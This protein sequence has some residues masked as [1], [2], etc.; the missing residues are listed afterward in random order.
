MPPQSHPT[1]IGRR[2]FIG[3]TARGA[4]K[5]GLLGASAPAILAACGRD[6]TGPG[7]GPAATS[8]PPTSQEG[9]IVGDVIDYALTSDE[10]PGAFGFVTLRLHRGVFQGK[11]VYFIRTDTSDESY[12]KQ[13]KLVW[14]PKLS[15]LIQGRLTGSAYVVSGGTSGQPTLLSSEPGRP[16]YTPAWR[17]HRV[18]WEQAPEL[19]SSIDDVEEARGAG[20]VTVEDTDIVLN[21]AV[22]RWSSE[23]MPVDT[24]RSEYLGGGQLLEPPD[25]SGMTV[26]F[27]LHECFPGVRYI[28][29]DTSLAPMAEGMHIAHSPGLAGSRDAGATGRT[30]VFMNGVKGPGPMG[31]QPSVFDSEAGSPEWS[32][33]WDHMTYGW[34]DG[35]PPRVLRAEQEVHA[36]RDGGD[37][38]EFPGTPETNGEIFTV[39]CPVPV[40][41]PN[42]FRG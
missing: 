22:V 37:L 23:E 38:D 9:P 7:A 3:W 15:S 33:Y 5:L 29:V 24:E 32:P 11:D 34:K 31:F 30:N 6:Q 13:E 26:M 35:V 8:P 21:A 1:E 14:A 28:V 2:E 39:N 27:K 4:L 42:T 16:E 25:T 12:A 10:W 18:S 20:R 40:L 41:A 19:L 36:A 17:L